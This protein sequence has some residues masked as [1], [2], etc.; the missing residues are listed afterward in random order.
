MV[1]GSTRASAEVS[2][3]RSPQDGSSFI[4]TGDTPKSI[5]EKLVKEGADL[6]SDVLKVAHHG[7]KTAKSDM[8]IEAVSPEIA[9]IEVGLNNQYGHPHQET[10]ESLEKYG[11]NTLRTDEDGDI[12]IF[13]DGKNLKLITSK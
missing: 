7:S 4:F 9:V 1:Y 5:E 12:K 3:K 8:F 13:S 2:P 6:D 10:L 11:I